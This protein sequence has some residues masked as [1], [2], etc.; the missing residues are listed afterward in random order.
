MVR[1]SFL[2]FAAQAVG[3]MATLAGGQ[4]AFQQYCESFN[5][6][7]S[8]VSGVSFAST[9]IPAGTELQLN[10]VDATCG[11]FTQAVTVNLCRVV[12]QVPTWNR[13]G[14]WFEAWLPED[15][16][17]RFLATG[18]GG[19]AGCIQYYDVEYG[20][21][22]GVATIATNNGHQG[23]TGAP[24]LHNLDV[25]QDFAYR[26]VEKGVSIGKQVAQEFYDKSH[27]K[28]YYLGCSTGGRQGL[29]AVQS[30]PDLFDGVVVGAP[31]IAW[32]NLTSWATRFYPLLGTTES[33]TFIPLDMWPVI[34]QDILDQCDTLDGVADG[35]LESPN[36]CNC[37][38]NDLLCT[39]GD[40][41]TSRCL[42]ATQLETL[43]SIYSPVLDAAGSLVYPKM[44]LG[45]EFTEAVDSYFSGA[46]SP[47]SDW[48]R[49]A[50]FNDSTWEPVT[51]RPENY[52]V[53]SGLNHFN[54]DTWEGDLGA[55]QSRGGKLLHWHGLADGV[56]SSENSP[57]YYEHVSQTMGMNSDALDTFYRYFRVSGMSHCGSGNGATFIGHQS[58]STAS[59]APEENVL[60]A[61]V[62]WV[63]NEVAPET[64]MGT[65][66]IDGSKD[67]GVDF[68]RRHCRWPYNNVYQGV[69]DYKDPNTWKCVL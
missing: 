33:A 18:N 42:T 66:Y 16:S 14:F 26:S 65:K 45:S 35:I 31:A 8:L 43:K 27:T 25:I 68:Q 15:W 22:L 52:T 61:V 67:N 59:L 24:F 64:L 21:S 23:Y 20:A 37:S 48:W 49:Y 50:I 5:A 51:F 36:L 56:L 17:G 28:S 3:V 1:R 40:G 12:G 39:E 55:F 63:E 29:K 57:R 62:E 46:V 4:A 47:V 41:Q 54:I 9:Y 30:F 19:L 11:I 53:A 6:S 69:G 10:E 58:A 60:M 7:T 38:P 34:H 44:Q 32:N 2:G 13:S